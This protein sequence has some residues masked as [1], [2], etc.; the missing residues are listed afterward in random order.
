MRE[1]QP[2][3]IDLIRVLNATAGVNDAL[4]TYRRAIEDPKRHDRIVLDSQCRYC[5]YV[6]RRIGGAAVT[7]AL[8]A[9]CGKVMTFGNT[10]TDLL[11]QSCAK[12][13]GLCR[14]CGADVN[15]K[16][17]RKIN[18]PLP[19]TPTASTEDK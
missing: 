18:L 5:F 15:G 12:L 8:C 17:R 7:Q 3:Q 4:E 16:M 19:P 13:S 11:C 6:S 10:S 2:Q 1:P 14:H 9:G